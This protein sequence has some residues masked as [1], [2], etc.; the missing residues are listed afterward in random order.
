M[1]CIYLDTNEYIRIYMYTYIYNIRFYV[2]TCVSGSFIWFIL[3]LHHSDLVV[4]SPDSLTTATQ[5]E[6]TKVYKTKMNLSWKNHWKTLKK[7][8]KPKSL[9]NHWKPNHIKIRRRVFLVWKT[10]ETKSHKLTWCI[11]CLLAPERKSSQPWLSPSGNFLSF[12]ASLTAFVRSQP[13]VLWILRELR[14][15]LME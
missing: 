2:W 1:P 12:A 11:G 14:P 10:I 5:C 6:T 13:K 15:L 4:W 9:K 3:R 8:L 7:T